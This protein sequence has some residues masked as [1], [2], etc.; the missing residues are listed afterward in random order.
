MYSSKNINDEKN[1]IDER[2]YMG[3]YK[4]TLAQN[5]L[6]YTV[7]GMLF[8]LFLLVCYVILAIIFETFMGIIGL[9]K[10]LITL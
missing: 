2:D 7:C 10:M 4:L 3:N 1:Y 5:C 6:L 9:I 8:F